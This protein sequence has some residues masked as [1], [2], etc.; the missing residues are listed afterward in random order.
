[1]SVR[2]LM[3]MDSTLERRTLAELLNI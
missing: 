2:D 1:M 3:L